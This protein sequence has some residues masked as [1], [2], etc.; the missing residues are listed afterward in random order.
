MVSAGT[1]VCHK[2][3]PS[4]QHL[5]V[6]Q[7][8][9][10]EVF[11]LHGD[12]ADTRH[13]PAPGNRPGVVTGSPGFT[14]TYNPVYKHVRRALDVGGSISIHAFGAFYGLAASMVSDVVTS[15]LHNSSM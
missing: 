11:R 10:S 12:M 15:S 4:L 3:V 13:P 7:I 1:L 5:Q 6:S 9:C 2:P 8:R 14:P